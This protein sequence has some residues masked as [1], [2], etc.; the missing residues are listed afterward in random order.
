VSTPPPSV[1]TVVPPPPR[2]G[3][4]LDESQRFVQPWSGWFRRVYEV[5]NTHGVQIANATNTANQASQDALAVSQ[6]LQ[7]GVG[8]TVTLARLTTAGNE[9]SMTFHSG[10]LTAYT[11]PT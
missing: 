7:Q 10:I 8:A 5:F 3:L 1:P 4:V 6:A 11:A 2:P 9:G